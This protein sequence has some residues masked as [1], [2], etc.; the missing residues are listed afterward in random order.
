M[1]KYIDSKNESY[2]DYMDRISNERIPAYEPELGKEE[3]MLL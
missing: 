2:K 1:N 3:L